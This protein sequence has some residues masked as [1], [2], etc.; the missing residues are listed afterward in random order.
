MYRFDDSHCK[1]L[2]ET[3]CL[4]DLINYL[5]KMKEICFHHQVRLSAGDSGESL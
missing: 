1:Q 3:D 5:G 2:G 4:Y